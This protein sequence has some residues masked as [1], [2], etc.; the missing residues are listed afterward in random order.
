VIRVFVEV[1]EEAAPLRM[2]VRAES[3]SQA[4]RTIEEVYPGR[5]VQVVFPIDPEEFFI[6]DSQ[7]AG[8]GHD[9]S[10]SL[11]HDTVRDAYLR[12]MGTSKN[13]CT[14]RGAE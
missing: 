10:R 3:I 1:H 2:I 4:V 9:R 5:T 13:G 7:D 8:A 14:R 11:V 12:R 6:E